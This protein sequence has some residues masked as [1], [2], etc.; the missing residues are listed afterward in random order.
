MNLELYH[1]IYSI[2]YPFL[3]RGNWNLSFYLCPGG[4]VHPVNVHLYYMIVIYNS[5]ET[6]ISPNL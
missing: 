2:I 5:R 3:G 1:I 4:C 6:R